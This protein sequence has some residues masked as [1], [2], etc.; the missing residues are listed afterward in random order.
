[1]GC[2][3]IA[4]RFL[5]PWAELADPSP[6][7]DEKRG[8]RAGDLSP[9]LDP[10]PLDVGVLAGK[11]KILGRSPPPFPF[12]TQV[13]DCSLAEELVAAF[14]AGRGLASSSSELSSL[15]GLFALADVISMS[16]SSLEA[17]IV[18]RETVDGNADAEINFFWFMFLF[19]SRYG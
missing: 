4:P 10:R 9:W 12:G 13:P 5:P 11:A 14:F 2:R 8:A 1:M 16:F 18:F 3:F 7:F 19:R 17:T 15:M 6:V